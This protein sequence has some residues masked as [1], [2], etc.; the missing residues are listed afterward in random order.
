MQ[1]AVSVEAAP[2]YVGPDLAGDG[3][4]GNLSSEYKMDGAGNGGLGLSSGDLLMAVT[5]RSV[6]SSGQDKPP[7][8][9]TLEI[10]ETKPV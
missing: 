10:K 5:L 4:G 1:W 8:G 9:K 2:P 6:F 7:N 3:E